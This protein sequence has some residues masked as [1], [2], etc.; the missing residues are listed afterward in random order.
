MSIVAALWPLVVQYLKPK[1]LIAKI[2]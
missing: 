2:T 1:L